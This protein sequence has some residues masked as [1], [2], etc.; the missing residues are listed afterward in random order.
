ME[1]EGWSLTATRHHHHH[2]HTN[3]HEYQESRET[4]PQLENL[5]TL[6]ETLTRSKGREDPKP[7]PDLGPTRPTW[8]EDP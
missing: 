8:N 5:D 7:T 6:V 4:E 3:L 2:H 1:L